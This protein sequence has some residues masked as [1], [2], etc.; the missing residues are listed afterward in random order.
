MDTK[1]IDTIKAIHSSHVQAAIAVTGGGAQALSWLM[2]IPG[3]SKTILNIDVPYSAEAL[4]NYLGWRPNKA[5]SGKVAKYMAH[6]AFQNAVNLNSAPSAVGIGVTATITTDRQKRG[7]HEFFVA[8]CTQEKIMVLS[9]KLTKGLRDRQGEDEIISK[10]IVK[11]LADKAEVKMDIPIGLRPT[12]N[13]ETH[14]YGSQ[15][16]LDDLLNDHISSAM[17]NPNGSMSN[18]DQDPKAILSGSFDPLHNGHLE[19]AKIASKILGFK[20]TFELAIINVDKPQLGKKEVLHRLSQFDEKAYVLLTNAATFVEK[21]RLLPRTTFIIGWDTATRLIDPRY[22]QNRITNMNHSLREIQKL[23]CQFL[24]AGRYEKGDFHSLNEVRIPTEFEYMFRS[25]PESQ[26][27]R[28][29]SSTEL[30]SAANRK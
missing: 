3:A 28:D 4:E 1:L 6:R 10:L 5:V 25:I 29:V 22:Y 2:E 8:V 19:L 18:R 9:A 7:E 27:R 14:T 21:A 26:F 20:V 23:G 15:Y 13:L 16:L 11:L 30:R 17:V 12:E 24:V